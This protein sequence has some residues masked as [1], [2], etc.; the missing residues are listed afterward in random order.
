MP[1]YVVE[2]TLLNEVLTYL[3][4]CP[5]GQVLNIVLAIKALKPEIEMEAP[6][7]PKAVK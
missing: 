3:G 7:K 1:K 2:E 5:C 4:T 6:L